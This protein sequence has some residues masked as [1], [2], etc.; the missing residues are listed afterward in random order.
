MYAHLDAELSPK[1][2]RA[3]TRNAGAFRSQVARAALVRARTRRVS[4]LRSASSTIIANKAIEITIRY[5]IGKKIPPCSTAHCFVSRGVSAS[6]RC[7]ESL[8]SGTPAG[9]RDRRRLSFVMMLSAIQPGRT[10]L[11]SRIHRGA[12]L[13]LL[14]VGV[15]LVPLYEACSLRAMSCCHHSS[16]VVQGTST[17]DPCCS[18]SQ[19]NDPAAISGVSP[20]QF[21]SLTA[22][23]RETSPFVPNPNQLLGRVASAEACHPPGP[24]LHVL[25]SVFLI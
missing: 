25:N 18:I 5:R 11:S 20:A 6:D 21:A 15:V 17:A 16:Q 19:G 2:G 14:L 3:R 10:S 7:H 12:G 4:C 23:P 22:V 9:M 1:S 13:M 8:W 24:P